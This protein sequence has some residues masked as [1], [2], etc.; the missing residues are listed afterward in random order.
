MANRGK[1]IPKS[2]DKKNGIIGVYPEID[3]FRMEV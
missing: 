2:A 3:L 1:V